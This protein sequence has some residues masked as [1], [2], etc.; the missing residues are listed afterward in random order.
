MQ[1]L[2]EDKFNVSESY[3]IISP[4]RAWSEAEWLETLVG[5]GFDGY[6][7]LTVNVGEVREHMVP[8]TSTTTI[9]RERTQK[10][11]PKKELPMALLGLAKPLLDQAVG[12]SEKRASK[13]VEKEEITTET[14]G[15]YTVVSGR[16]QYIIRLVDIKNGNVVWMGLN[17]IN[18]DP[19]ARLPG[20][21]EE[22]AKQLLH[23][24]PDLVL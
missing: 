9:K 15:G 23:D 22:I 5:K 1:T 13:A 16:T 8:P 12:S 14:R 24:L 6:L 11:E 17:E 7:H 10:E 20:F 2:R 21:C 4:T 19:N 18:G 3:A